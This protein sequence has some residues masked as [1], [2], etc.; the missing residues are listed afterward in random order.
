MS[1]ATLTRRLAV[2]VATPLA[3]GGLTL[4]GAAPAAA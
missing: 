4:A 2:L 3:T 1:V